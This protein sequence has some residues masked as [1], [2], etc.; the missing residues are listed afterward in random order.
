MSEG[1]W[2]RIGATRV[3]LDAQTV[4]GIIKNA[5]GKIGVSVTQMPSLREDI[6]NA[7]LK[8]VTPFVPM[9]TKDEDADNLRKS[10]RATDDGRVYWT[11]INSRGDNYASYVFDEDE[12]RW[13]G[14]ATY[15]NPST[16]GTDP[17]WIRN[18]QPGT[19]AYK[20]FIAE[21]TE[22]IRKEFAKYE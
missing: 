13:P 8:A 14:E 6:G 16:E 21:A 12:T 22:I 17:R 18:V 15:A 3:H 4:N 9:K 5:V 2:V 1:S 19:D 20:G 10:G 7:Y 11:A